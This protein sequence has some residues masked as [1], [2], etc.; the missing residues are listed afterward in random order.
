MQLATAL[1]I[2]ILISL[3]LDSDIFVASIEA[4]NSFL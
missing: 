4:S 1:I 3:A 2:A